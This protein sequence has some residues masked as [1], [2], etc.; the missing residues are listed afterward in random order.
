[1][2]AD[3]DRCVALGNVATLERQLLRLCIRKFGRVAVVQRGT[4]SDDDQTVGVHVQKTTKNI[5]PVVVQEF[6]KF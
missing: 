3:S 6:G 5:S 1:M 4:E 2:L